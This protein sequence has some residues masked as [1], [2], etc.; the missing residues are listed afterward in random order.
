[1]YLTEVLNL[2]SLT[3]NP[4]GLHGD[5]NSIPQILW[6]KVTGRPLLN[7]LV[8]TEHRKQALPILKLYKNIWIKDP[9]TAYFY[10]LYSGERFL[11]GEPI[12]ATSGEWSYFYARRVIKGPWPPGE[13]AVLTS[14]SANWVCWYV[15][16]VLRN[17]NVTVPTAEKIM[18]RRVNERELQNSQLNE[19]KHYY[20]KKEWFDDA[21]EAGY[22]LVFYSNFSSSCKAFNDDGKCVGYWIEGND[23]HNGMTPKGFLKKE[24]DLYSLTDNPEAL[25]HYKDYKKLRKL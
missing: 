24:L 18:Q 13:K 12:I 14:D 10:A 1:M 5:P 2:Y 3:D 11:E 9:E 22:E 20:E 15:W 4:E 21:K 19:S 16:H 23:L 8:S 25:N 6:Q 17:P 7:T